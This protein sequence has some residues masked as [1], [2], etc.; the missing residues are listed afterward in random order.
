VVSLGPVGILRY[1]EG[2]GF[3]TPS[4]LLYLFMECSGAERL[5]ECA[6]P[7]IAGACPTAV[8]RRRSLVLRCAGPGGWSP[9]NSR[10]C[11]WEPSAS[12]CL[13]RASWRVGMDAGTL[14]L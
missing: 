3:P 4:A 6:G 11:E 14:A 10:P 8:D 1:G 12:G 7:G 2:I 5:G 13:R 9:L